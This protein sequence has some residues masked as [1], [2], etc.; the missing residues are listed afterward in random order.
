MGEHLLPKPSGGN[1]LDRLIERKQMSTKTLRKRIALVAVSA[2]GFGMV[3]TVSA[4]AE[5]AASVTNSISLYQATAAPKVGSAVTTNFTANVDDYTNIAADTTHTYVGYL[6]TYPSGGFVQVSATADV[7]TIT[8]TELWVGPADTEVDESVSGASFIATI[9]SDANTDDFV[10]NTLTASATV[11]TASFAFTPTVPGT[12]VLTVFNDAGTLDGAINI[13][14]AVQTISIVVAEATAWSQGLSTSI[15]QNVTDNTFDATVD[16]EIR[17]SSAVGTNGMAIA[18]TL[19]DTAGSAINGLRV[20]AEVSGAGLVDVVTGGTNYA[21]ATVRADALTLAAGVNTALVHVTA[22][23]TAGLG[24]ITVKIHNPVTLAVLGS[25]TET[26][27]FYGTVATLEAT[28]NFTIARASATERGCTAASVVTVVTGGTVAVNCA[29]T[30]FADTPFVTIVAKD[31]GGNL[32]PG[33][34]V[35]SSI[36]NPAIVQASTVT[37]VTSPASATTAGISTDPNGLGYYNASVAGATTAV[38]GT[39]TTITYYTALANGTLISA[40]PVTITIGGSAAT[41]TET[42]S[43][44]K[45]TYASGEGM[46]VTLTAKDSAGN[47]VYDGYAS[48]AVSFNKATGGSA[49]AASYYVAGKVTS[50]DALGRKTIYAP[51][52]SGAFTATATAASLA[53]LTATA[54]IGDDA[55]TVAAAAAADAAAEATDAANA[56]TDAANAAAEAADAATA[57]AQDAADAVAALSV[58]VTEMVNALKK[59]ITSLTNLVIKIQKKVKA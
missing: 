27:N 48:P 54:S 26:I 13:G 23:G 21:D 57:A 16:E 50:D 14:E 58:S 42:L 33:L 43:L 32:V 34:T 59:Q 45:A 38:S 29:Q 9:D 55:A 7:A 5:G 3:S 49:V 6:S 40:S 8:D 10:G 44:D 22:D 12:Y 18:L 20:S 52:A 53:T 25:F 35:A 30:T 41:G 11:A 47:P 1:S 4:N 46:T 2:L 31:A 28:A 51:T 39:S 24:T 36:A 17:V 56:A 19:K 37:A 15:R